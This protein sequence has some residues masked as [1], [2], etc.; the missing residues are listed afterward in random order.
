[1]GHYLSWLKLEKWGLLKPGSKEPT[2]PRRCTR[3]NSRA[4]QL[5]LLGEFRLPR[6][7]FHPLADQVRRFGL[8]QLKE[9][10]LTPTYTHCLRPFKIE[11]KSSPFS[12][13]LKYRAGASYFP[14]QSFIEEISSNPVLR[15]NAKCLLKRLK[16]TILFSITQ[17]FFRSA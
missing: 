6:A 11:S 17:I 9:R 10:T 8:K 2:G 13:S 14:G 5:L 12:L 16:S 7:S 3:C 4:S 15:Q 1:M